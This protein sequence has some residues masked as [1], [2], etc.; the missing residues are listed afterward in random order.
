MA[1]GSVVGKIQRT[2]MVRPASLGAVDGEPVDPFT[3]AGSA[4]TTADSTATDSG[5][6]PVCPHPADAHDEIGARFCSATA[7]GE[8]ERGCVCT[9]TE[10]R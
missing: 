3:T 9:A 6:C 5:A 2:G 10:S 8:F 7:A 1:P 4:T